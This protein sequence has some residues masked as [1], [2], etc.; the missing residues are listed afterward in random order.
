MNGPFTF[1][2]FSEVEV[3]IDGYTSIV[4]VRR[5]KYVKFA[6]TPF[7]YIINDLYQ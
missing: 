3:V 5:E 2:W 4:L 1:M 7:S 6:I